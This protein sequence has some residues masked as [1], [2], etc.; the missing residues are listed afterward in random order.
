MWVRKVG[1]N[2]TPANSVQQ[3]E[4]LHHRNQML[5][6]TSTASMRF[7]HY[8]RR[9]R[10]LKQMTFRRR[11]MIIFYRAHEGWVG[12]NTRGTPQGTVQRTSNEHSHAIRVADHVRWLLD[13]LFVA[14]I[15]QSNLASSYYSHYTRSVLGF[16]VSRYQFKRVY[17]NDPTCEELNAPH[18]NLYI[19]QHFLSCCCRW[20]PSLDALL[21]AETNAIEFQW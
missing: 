3:S 18:H 5:L 4:G 6:F 16:V 9:L 7:N 21:K 13:S 10:R 20:K 15:I 14:R 8:A 11:Q 1:L 12:Y 2:C 17:F 19:W